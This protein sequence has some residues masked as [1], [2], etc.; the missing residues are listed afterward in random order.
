[1]ANSRA[2]GYAIRHGATQDNEKGVFRSWTHLPLTAQGEKQA[3][4][5]AE[6]LN[7]FGIQAIFSSPLERALQTAQKF[8]EVSGL[9]ITQDNRLMGWKTGAFEGLL[10]DEVE[11]AMALFVENSDV[12]PPLGMSLDEFEGRCADFLDEYLPLAEKHGPFAFF[13]HNSNITAFSN[14]MSGKRAAH[15]AISEISHP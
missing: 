11:E 1:M 15:P 3:E 5:A 13:C 8:S 10:E 7:G 4:E 14:L 12:P 9:P 6:T 2:I